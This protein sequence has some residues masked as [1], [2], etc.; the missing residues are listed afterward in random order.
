M[1]WLGRDYRHVHIVASRNQWSAAAGRYD[2]R[3]DLVL[4]LDFGLRRQIEA[5]GGTVEYLDRLGEQAAMQENN[6]LAGAFFRTWHHDASG[7]DLFTA[8]GIPFGFAF[9]IEMWSEFLG[10]V[11]LRA[12]LEQL[13]RWAIRRFQL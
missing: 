13:R 7:N 6:F 3:R 11:R 1:T 10:Y 5:A 12:S 8:R 9:R 2:P 4:T